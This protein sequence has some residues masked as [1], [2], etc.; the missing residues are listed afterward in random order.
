VSKGFKA[1]LIIGMSTIILLQFILIINLNLVN[2]S[3]QES[4]YSVKS[5]E[6]SNYQELSDQT[7]HINSQLQSIYN[8]MDRLSSQIDRKLR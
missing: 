1:I 8:Y 3:I 4:I 7:D 2:S 6:I 5:R